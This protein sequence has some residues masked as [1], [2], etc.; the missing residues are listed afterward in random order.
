MGFFNRLLQSG[1]AALNE[2]RVNRAIRVTN[3]AALTGVL[4]FG[5]YIV[6]YMVLDPVTFLPSI[7]IDFAG[8]LGLSVVLVLNR[9]MHTLAAT[10][11]MNLSI[12]LPVFLNEVLFFGYDTGN[13]S[14][15]ILCAVLPAISFATKRLW[16]PAVLGIA[17]VLYFSL[18]FKR[19]PLFDLKPQI[20]HVVLSGMS[21]ASQFLAIVGIVVTVSFYQIALNRNER[22]LE[23]KSAALRKSLEEVNRLANHDGL[24]GLM[25]RRHLETRI[26]LEIERAERYGLRLSMIMF[27]LDHF[28]I[29]ND[30]FGHE[31]GDRVLQRTGEIATHLVRSSDLVGRWG[32]EE[33]IVLLPQ[34]DLDGA[35]V[36]AEK[37]RH[38]MND[39][40]GRVHMVTGSFGV[41]EWLPEE[42]FATFY[43]RVDEALYCAKNTGRNRVAASMDAS[44]RPRPVAHI[45]WKHEWDSGDPLIDRQHRGLLVL[46][47]EIISLSL[48]NIEREP[49][50]SLLDQLLQEI[51]EHFDYEESV[52][53]RIRFIGLEAH[54]TAHRLLLQRSTELKAQVLRG[55]A[56]TVSVFIFVLEEVVIGHI[57]QEDSAY[58]K[59]LKGG[60][61]KS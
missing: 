11:L 12:S 37:L 38:A 26:Q 19:L 15:L 8:V 24:T 56:Q 9:R 27:D 32:G 31:E 5:I 30:S 28:K 6:L 4:L 57:I 50:L 59:M 60:S 34:T 61:R 1:T 35:M 47:N 2:D 48:S 18:S 41:A 58:F 33:F 51:Q 10:V 14:I 40:L 23:A 20:P 13:H 45:D 55:E 54:R 52:L 25:N 16:I 17:N 21:D 46:A 53:E 43:G 39:D 49:A 29:V 44:L 22:S 36:S 42:T 7:L 3:I